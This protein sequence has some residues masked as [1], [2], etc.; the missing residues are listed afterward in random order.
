MNIKIK[1]CKHLNDKF[2]KAKISIVPKYLC[3]VTAEQ[4]NSWFKY[5]KIKGKTPFKIQNDS[6]IK[7]DDDIQR[8]LI[9]ETKTVSQE[10]SKIEEIKDTLLGKSGSINAKAYLGS[11]IWNVR[12]GNSKIEIFETGKKESSFKEYELSIEC[13]SIMLPD[14]AHRHLAICESVKDYIEKPDAYTAFDPKIEFPVEL[15]HLNE[16]QERELFLELNSKQKKV[17][18]SRNLYVDRN[19]PIGFLK[20]R[21]MEMDEEQEKL[22]TNNIELN[23]NTNDKHTLV[24]MSVL[25]S[26]LDEM[27]GKTEIKKV[28]DNP[29]LAD[30]MAEYF[31]KF[32]YEI[33]NTVKIKVDLD[34]R[35][36]EINPYQNLYTEIVTKEECP[37]T[38][39]EALERFWKPKRDKAIQIN[40]E[41]RKQDIITN[42]QFF[43]TLAFIGGIV[44]EFED[45]LEVVRLLQKRIAA[46]Q[47]RF[48][49]KANEL[50]TQS[51]EDDH[52]IATI[53]ADG[54]L[55]V[56]IMDWNLKLCKK[57]IIQELKL[58]FENSFL[59]YH[60]G[61]IIEI[62]DFITK[63]NVLCSRG[64]ETNL[65]LELLVCVGAKTEINAEETKLKIEPEYSD[66]S[67]LEWVGGTFTGKNMLVPESITSVDGYSHET[68]GKNIKQYSIKYA[69][70][71]KEFDIDGDREFV[72]KA[73]VINKSFLCEKSNLKIRCQP[74]A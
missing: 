44:R 20:S 73:S 50:I 14:S 33:K 41:I 22:F 25:V 57:L 36:Q 67:P 13:E 43:K 1:L 46:H 34:G 61:N 59:L 38:S 65:V 49:Q 31:L 66:A 53:N 5:S 24:T 64:R 70:K 9:E 60:E 71:L 17:T 15:Y 74:S 40:K 47:G 42:N 21:I 55:N 28:K 63:K 30:E 51:Q 62:K 68:Y 18:R 39:E 69:L 6:L 23:G 37:D 2:D 7:I 8:G 16:N 4:I 52:Q 26:S 54:S 58:N 19:S 29:N 56:Q 3:V 10:K 11:L 45:P 27:F 35:S 48:F 12:N 72:L 32:F